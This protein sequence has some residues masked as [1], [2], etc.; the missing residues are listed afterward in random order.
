MDRI[1][2]V[3]DRLSGRFYVKSATNREAP[4]TRNLLSAR[5]TFLMTLLFFQSLLTDLRYAI[6]DIQPSSLFV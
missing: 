5:R 3:L 6:H 4:Q 2:T 1:H